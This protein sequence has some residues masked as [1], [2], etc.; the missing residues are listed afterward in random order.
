MSGYGLSNMRDRAEICGGSL[1]IV[2]KPGEGTLVQL[3]LEADS[4]ALPMG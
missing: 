2:S 3:A 4:F 1:K